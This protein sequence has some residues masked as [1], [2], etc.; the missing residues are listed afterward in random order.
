MSYYPGKQYSHQNAK[1]CL[2]CGC[3]KSNHVHFRAGGGYRSH[4]CTTA[5][6]GHE[7]PAYRGADEEIDHAGACS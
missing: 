7:C 5:R 3:L 1:P 6:T 4:S 2:D